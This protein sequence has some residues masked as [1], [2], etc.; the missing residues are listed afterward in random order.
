VNGTYNLTNGLLRAPNIL[1]G[2]GASPSL[3]TQVGGTNSTSDL[4]VRG[5][6][7]P[8]RYD[9]SGGVLT[10]GSEEIFSSSRTALGTFNQTGGRNTVTNTL[11]LAGV[12][13]RS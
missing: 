9:L 12:R 7:A 3:F 5:A 10:A 6:A 11:R 2:G 8:A 1:V 13:D 4:V